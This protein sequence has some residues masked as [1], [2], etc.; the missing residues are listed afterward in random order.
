[1]L[2]THTK[3]IHRTQLQQHL[4]AGADLTVIEALPKK[5]FDEAHLPGAINIRNLTQR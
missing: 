4:E 3:T 1:M 5:Y 2:N